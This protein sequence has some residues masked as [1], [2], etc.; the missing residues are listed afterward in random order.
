MVTLMEVADD[1]GMTED[2]AKKTASCFGVGMLQGSICG[3]VTGAFLAIGYAHGNTVPNDSA[4]K[5]LVMA[6]KEEF[7]K[8]FTEEFGD[9]TCPALLGGLDLRKQE[10]MAEARQKELLSKFCPKICKRSAEIV[11]TVV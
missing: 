7:L 11:K 1:I 6:K 2:Q 4:Q 9:I 5:G 8:E 10:D 3:A